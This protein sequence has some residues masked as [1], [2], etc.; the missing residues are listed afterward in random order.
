M[1]HPVCPAA[2]EEWRSSRLGQITDALEE[3]LLLDLLGPVRGLAVLDVGCGDGV[4]ASALARRGAQ[5]TGL[6]N[7][8][9]DVCRGQ[10]P[11]SERID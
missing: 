11:G 2:Y 7:G 8:S 3:R 10:A 6:D 1:A 4:L 5:V 9:A